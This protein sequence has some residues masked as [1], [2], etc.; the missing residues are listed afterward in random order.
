M[1]YTTTEK[2]LLAIIYSV[3][4]FRVYL[5]G[6]HFEVVYITDHKSL[7]FLQSASFQGGRIMRWILLLQQYNILFQ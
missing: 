3:G 4:K 5:I 6:R 1:K 2:E 7:I